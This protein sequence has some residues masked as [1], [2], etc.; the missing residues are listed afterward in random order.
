MSSIDNKYNT[1]K[2]IK[3]IIKLEDSRAKFKVRCR[4]CGHTM[5][6]VDTDKTICSHCGHWI[7]KT[8]ELEFKYRLRERMIKNENNNKKKN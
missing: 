4:H 7:F 8:P 3:D 5:V 6:I 2:S 1:K